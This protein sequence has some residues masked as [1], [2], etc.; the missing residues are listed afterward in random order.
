MFS[1]AQPCSVCGGRGQVVEDACQTCHGSGFTHQTKRYRVKIPAGVREG[2]RIRLAGKGEPGI[3]GGPGGDLYVITRVSPS[4]VFKRK[5]DH[6]EVD[7][8]LTIVE[9]IRGGTVEVP[10]LGGTKKIRVP[11]GTSHGNVQRLR[12]EGPSRL[13]GSGRGDIHY[14]FAIQIP[15]SLTQEQRDAMDELSK[16]MNGNPR[17]ELLDRARKEA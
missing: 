4:P 15:K 10:T 17:A 7:V 3:G 14:R 12:G 16:V 1:M 9:A 2:S 6:V 13:S 8:P 11:P 5:G